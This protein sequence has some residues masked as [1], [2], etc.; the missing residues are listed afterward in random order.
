M[1]ITK[2]Q[3]ESLKT[4]LNKIAK[5]NIEIEIICDTIY[6]YCS[7][8]ASLRLLKAYRKAENANCGFSENLNTFYFRIE[9]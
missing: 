2:R 1:T 6:A 8:L 5:E 4:D 7:E 9:L 3:I